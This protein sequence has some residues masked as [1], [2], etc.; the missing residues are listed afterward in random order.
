[1]LHTCMENLT[2]I[3]NSNLLSMF[4]DVLKIAMI[5]GNIYVS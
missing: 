1:M 5:K 4:I 2:R 3:N